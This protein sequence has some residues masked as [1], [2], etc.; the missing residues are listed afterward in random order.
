LVNLTQHA[1][2]VY[3]LKAIPNA[4][5]ESSRNRSELVNPSETSGYLKLPSAKRFSD[6]I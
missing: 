4:S 5:P 6:F 1:P 2:E 3:G